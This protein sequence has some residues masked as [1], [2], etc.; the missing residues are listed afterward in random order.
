[1][2]APRRPHVP[3]VVGGET[4]PLHDGFGPDIGLG[5]VPQLVE[6]DQASCMRMMS[7]GRGT[8]EKRRPRGTVF[9]R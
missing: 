4:H 7:A 9:T 6:S 5:L 2:I 3:F 8:T 1:V